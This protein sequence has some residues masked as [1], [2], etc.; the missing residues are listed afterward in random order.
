VEP[1][2]ETPGAGGS[3]TRRAVL[4]GSV[5]LAGALLVPGAAGA[6]DAAGEAPD[7]ASADFLFVQTA[8]GS[9]FDAGQ[10]RLTLNG[11]SP[12]TMFFSDRPER[13]AGNMKTEAFVPFWSEGS[14]SFLADPPNADLSII[15]DGALKQVVVVLRDPVLEGD[16]LHYTVQILDGEMPVLGEEVSLFIDVIGMPLTPVSYAGAARRGYRRAVL[17]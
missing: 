11:V 1:G 13:I 8:A 7:G 3:P 4:A 6:Q 12:V 14:D 5:G 9:A 2:D 15:E 16:S 17:Y 10:N